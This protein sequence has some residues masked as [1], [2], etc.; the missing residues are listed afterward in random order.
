MGAGLSG[1]GGL[2]DSG[3]YRPGGRALGGCRGSR[4]RRHR[5]VGPARSPPSPGSP[6]SWGPGWSPAAEGPSGPCAGSRRRVSVALVFCL[7]WIPHR[8]TRDRRGRGRVLGRGS[9]LVRGGHPAG[10]RDPGSAPGAP[11]WRRGRGVGRCTRRGRA[12]APASADRPAC[13]RA[14]PAGRRGVAGLRQHRPGPA[15]PAAIGPRRPHSRWPTSGWPNCSRCPGRRRA[16]TGG[17]GCA[18]RWCT[19]AR[20]GGDER[21]I[22]AGRRHAVARVAGGPAARM[23]AV[24]TVRCSIRRGS[25]CGGGGGSGVRGAQL[26]P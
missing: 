17:C 6:S 18:T 14:A 2:V 10:R 4:R 25:G 15:G 16:P 3:R 12:A 19:G 7:D 24:R 21:P 13:D 22:G 8:W 23:R 26:S 9:V 11:C 1:R 5:R 20:G